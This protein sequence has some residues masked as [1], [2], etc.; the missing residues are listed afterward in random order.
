MAFI[1]FRK[2]VRSK[3]EE[4]RSLSG[5][6]AGNSFGVAFEQLARATPQSGDRV[7]EE[8]D[9]LEVLQKL[10]D[11]DVSDIKRQLPFLYV[12]F[13]QQGILT[14]RQLE[15]LVSSK[16]IID[17]L[18]KLYTEKLNRPADRPL[19][20]MAVAT[21]GPPLFNYGSSQTIIANIGGILEKSDEALRK[22]LWVSFAPGVDPQMYMGQKNP[23]SK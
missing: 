22:N 17:P 14:R 1:L 8:S 3:L 13:R 4:V 23:K 7:I 5:Q 16:D 15:Q 10:P 18:K 20:P 11:L 19:D 9:V 6:F 2:Q 21:Y 12:R